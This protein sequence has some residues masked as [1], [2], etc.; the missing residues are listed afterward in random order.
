MS[1]PE[2]SAEII[3]SLENKP[4]GLARALE[5]V[6]E[7]GI[8]LE[9]VSAESVG[10]YGTVRLWSREADRLHDVLDEEGFLVTQ[11]PTV[12]VRVPNEPGELHR[13]C[14]RLGERDIN[15]ESVFCAAY[16]D[17]AGDIVIQTNDIEAAREALAQ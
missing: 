14:R 6:E 17:D 12:F 10:A 13:I 3:L 8:N 15:I 9:G 11:R 1:E 16:R 4:G 5:V 2:L 7:A